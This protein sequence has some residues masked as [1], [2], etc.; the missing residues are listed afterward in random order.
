MWAY[1]IGIPFRLRF[2]PPL[3]LAMPTYLTLK[4]EGPVHDRTARYAK[5]LWTAVVPLLLVISVESSVVRPD[6]LGK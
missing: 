6:L 3:R 5:L 1:S 2:L 4:T